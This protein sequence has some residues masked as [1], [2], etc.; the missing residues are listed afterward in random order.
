M[1]KCV[2]TV[3]G[4]VLLLCLLALP[5]SAVREPHQSLQGA[6]YVVDST[7]DP[8]DGF[9]DATDCTL[10]EAIYS[11]NYDG[12][13]SNIAFNIPPSD[14]GYNF[15]TGVWT[16]YLASA[17]PIL[18]EEGTGVMGSTQTG[19]QGDTNPYGPEVVV[20]GSGSHECFT[21]WSQYNTIQGLVINAC[22]YG[23]KIASVGSPWDPGYN[24]ISGNYLGTNYAGTAAAGNIEYGIAI[25]NAHHNTIGG[26]TAQERNIISGNGFCGVNIYGAAAHDNEVIGNYVGTNADGTGALPNGWAGIVIDLGAHDNTIG[27]VNPGERNIIS[28]NEPGISIGKD[29]CYN[30]VTG[31]YIGTDSSGRVGVGNLDDGVRIGGG[32]QR[33]YIGPNNIIAYNGG[34]GVRIAGSTTISNTITQNSIHS[35]VG[36][37]IYLVDEANGNLAAPYD[38][39]GLCLGGGAYGGPLLQWEAFSDFD[40]Q[41]RFF[42]STGG[43][44]TGSF[45]FSPADVLFRYPYVTLTVTDEGGNTSEFSEPVPSGCLF[46]YLPLSMKAY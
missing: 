41:G 36:E 44:D 9:C 32:A 1:R 6:D 24:T 21:I 15:L 28:G 22:K 30:R 23:V 12:G 14:D 2:L 43:T 26:T 16:I 4:L 7:K 11:A 39:V 18:T 40:G 33:N 20:N 5:T 27:G 37:G 8:G 17:L 19:N 10:R 34:S 3:T 25:D 35:N 42:E 29:A 46:G 13:P 31:N 38:V 45:S